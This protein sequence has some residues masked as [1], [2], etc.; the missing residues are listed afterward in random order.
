MPVGIDCNPIAGVP[1][2]VPNNTHYEGQ[3]VISTP[4]HCQKLSCIG[5]Q[6]LVALIIAFM[7]KY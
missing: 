3:L 5:D 2:I 1:G 6:V 4:F 7:T